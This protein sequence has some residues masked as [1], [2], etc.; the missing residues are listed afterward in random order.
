MG[1]Y[2]KLLENVWETDP[3][4]EIFGGYRENEIDLS[5]RENTFLTSEEVTKSLQTLKTL[6]EKFHREYVRQSI[7]RRR[8]IEQNNK[9]LCFNV[10]IK[11]G[12]LF[13]YMENESVWER[14]MAKL[15]NISVKE[16]S[17]ADTGDDSHI[18][19]VD[20]SNVPDYLSSED[21]QRLFTSLNDK[22]ITTVFTKAKRLG[23]L[24]KQSKILEDEGASNDGFVYCTLSGSEEK[25]LSQRRIIIKSNLY[26]TNMNYLKELP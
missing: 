8:A 20:L 22:G 23:K 3:E 12:D 9:Q 17:I 1:L 16:G 7:C 4:K 11:N 14:L 18:T 19:V 2:I 13:L 5:D 21:K 10:F 15:D 25:I 6:T 26:M 24:G